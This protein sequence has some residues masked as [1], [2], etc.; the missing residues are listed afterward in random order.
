[1]LYHFRVPSALVM[2]AFHF[3][4]KAHKRCSSVKSGADAS[5]RTLCHAF[6]CGMFKNEVISKKCLDESAP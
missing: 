3:K 5:S 1:M 2:L 4:I 6:M